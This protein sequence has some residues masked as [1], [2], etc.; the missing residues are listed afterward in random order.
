MCG[1]NMAD[2]RNCGEEFQ[3]RRDRNG[4]RDCKKFIFFWGEKKP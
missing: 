2:E 3:F 1:K 4:G